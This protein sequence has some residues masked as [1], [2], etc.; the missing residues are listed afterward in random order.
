MNSLKT[1]ENYIKNRDKLLENMRQYQ[2]RNYEKIK[3]DKRQY[4]IENLDKC[5][6]WNKNWR[7]DNP[8][9]VRERAKKYYK[10]RSQLISNYKLLKGCAICGYNK[11]ASALCFHHNGDKKFDIAMGHGVGFKELKK[12]VEKCVVICANC[13][14]ELHEKIKSDKL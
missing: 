4:Q 6:E 2:K 3:E 1:A 14:A 13:H 9:K 10:K 7:K 11:C 8:K 5:A 12:E